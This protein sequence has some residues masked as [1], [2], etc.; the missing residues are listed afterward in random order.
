M[1]T[2]TLVATFSEA[3]GQSKVDSR[4]IFIM[5]NVGYGAY[6]ASTGTIGLSTS[7]Q[8]NIRRDSQPENVVE[9]PTP[10]SSGA[11]RGRTRTSQAQVPS[12]NF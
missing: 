8:I 9:A 5:T 6:G 11:T 10:V 2:M 3:F 12:R 1:G 7:V 4:V